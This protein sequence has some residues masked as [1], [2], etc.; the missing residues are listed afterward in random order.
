MTEPASS[1]AG[2]VALWK[3]CAAVLGIG[4]VGGGLSMLFLW[5]KTL[6]EA[7]ARLVATIAG[8]FTLGV[9]LT[10][11]AYLKFPEW[12][13]ASIRLLMLI[14]MSERFADLAGPFLMAAPF[15]FI[16]GLPFWWL[17]GWFFRLLDKNKD[18]DLMEVAKE[19]KSGAK[20]LLP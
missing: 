17:L 5:P 4:V 20:E 11:L 9:G 14:G 15:L 18:K 10:V 6:R 7:F 13:D 2:G 8:S 1:T 19:L 16:G 3:L 12:F